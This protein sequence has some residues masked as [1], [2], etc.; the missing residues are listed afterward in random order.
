MTGNVNEWCKD[1]Y[2]KYFYGQSSNIDPLCKDNELGD[3]VVRG[4]LRYDD[5]TWFFPISAN[6][7]VSARF[8]ELPSI[9][10]IYIGFRCVKD[11]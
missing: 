5:T 7:R 10:S 11:E 9:K 2:Q 6:L 1:R 4:G 3:H 8:R